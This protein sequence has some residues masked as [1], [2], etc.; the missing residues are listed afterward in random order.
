MSSNLEAP[1]V[2]VLLSGGMDSAACVDF[3]CELGRHQ[4]ALFIDYQQ[5]AALQESTAAAAIA[6]YYGIPLA[7]LRL[8]GSI[9]KTE[10]LISARNAF[11]LATAMLERPASVTG[12]AIGVHSGTAYADCSPAFIAATQKVF[13]FY[14]D[15][16]VQVVA[17]F[18]GW[19]KAEIWA[20]CRSRSVPV[21]LSYSCEA[22]GIKPCGRC[23]SCLDREALN[24]RP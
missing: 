14:S 8:D 24:A 20:Y 3:F 18:I 10:G 17:P 11:L 2:L 15:G 5:P 13:S 19:S 1:E 23:L 9:R 4:M 16:R 7:K 21:E 12:I 6:E 22:G